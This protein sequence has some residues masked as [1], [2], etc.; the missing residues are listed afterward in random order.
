MGA[1]AVVMFG[2]IIGLAMITDVRKIAEY[3]C[4]LI[5]STTASPVGATTTRSAP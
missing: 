5:G 3:T 2:G 4:D 1:I